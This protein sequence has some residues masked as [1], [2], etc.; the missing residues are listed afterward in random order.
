MRDGGV[1]R[2]LG[3]LPWASSAE[4]E[5]RETDPQ[6]ERTTSARARGV[7]LTFEASRCWPR[8]VREATARMD[9]TAC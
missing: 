1:E 6:M 4:G 9:V 5:P 3:A 7:A 8:R 2:A